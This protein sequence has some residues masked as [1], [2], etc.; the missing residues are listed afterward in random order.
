[1]FNEKQRQILDAAEKL[2]AYKGFDGTSIRDIAKAAH[3]NIAMISYYFGSKEKLLHALFEDRTE[4]VRSRLKSVLEDETLEPMKKLGIVVDEY[5]ERIWEKPRFFK[6]MINEQIFERNT[7]V[8]RLVKEMKK[9]NM[10]LID[11][12]IKEGQ[13]KKLFKKGVDT[14]LLTVT[15]TGVALQSMLNKEYHKEFHQ[16]K[17]VDNAT[18]EQQFKDKTKAHIKSLFKAILSHEA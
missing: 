11:K 14:V 9:Q 3:V 4:Q 13:K 16:Y 17:E 2:F 15:M 7:L 18:V 6:V 5:V 1:M 8:T 12:L 10:E